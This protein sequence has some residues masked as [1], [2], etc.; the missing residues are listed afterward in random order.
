MLKFESAK[1]GEEV[2]EC[3]NSGMRGEKCVS[4]LVKLET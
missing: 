3:S 4:A 1:V 2:L